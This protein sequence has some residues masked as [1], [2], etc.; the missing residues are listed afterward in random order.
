MLTIR[1]MLKS[2]VVTHFGSVTK[3]AEALDITVSAVSLWGD[4]IPE[5]RAYQLES[6]TK[7][8][9]KVDPAVYSDKHTSSASAQRAAS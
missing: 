3:V 8:A 6:I 7:R 5:G 2:A 1:S 9:L 4:V